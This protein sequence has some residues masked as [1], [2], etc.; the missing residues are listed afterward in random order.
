[1]KQYGTTILTYGIGV[2]AVDQTY[3][4]SNGM[5]LEGLLYGHQKTMRRHTTSQTY[6][7]HRKRSNKHDWH[8]KQQG[9]NGIIYHCQG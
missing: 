9:R 5:T 6:N 4:G 7:M 2:H 8:L 3:D 1:M